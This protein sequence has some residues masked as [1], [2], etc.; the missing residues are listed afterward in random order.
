M[1]T[2][3]GRAVSGGSIVRRPPANWQV[4]RAGDPRVISRPRLLALTRLQPWTNLPLC[5]RLVLAAP[6][7]APCAVRPR[8]LKLPCGRSP[9]VTSLL[10]RDRSVRAE[11]ASRRYAERCTAKP[12]DSGAW[13][14]GA[15]DPATGPAC[16]Q[17]RRRH[18]TR[19]VAA[20]CSGTQHRL[21]ASRR[22]HTT[23][24]LAPRRS[25][26]RTRQR[27]RHRSLGDRGPRSPSVNVTGRGLRPVATQAR[28]MSSL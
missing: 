12:C 1:N 21:T 14:R 6:G 5:G 10:R 28:S 3:Q 17:R 16:R 8:Q 4:A 2:A 26:S 24:A 9:P 11:G 23:R 7:A 27:H 19:C 18:Q 15:P 22:L 25:G 20:P 13:R